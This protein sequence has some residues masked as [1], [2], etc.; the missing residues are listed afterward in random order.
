MVMDLGKR[1]NFH[2]GAKLKYFIKMCPV[3]MPLKSLDHI[4]LISVVV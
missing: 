2:H 3:Q 4:L 1:E